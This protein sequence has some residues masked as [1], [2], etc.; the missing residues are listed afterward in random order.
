MNKYNKAMMLA[1]LAG[2]A[3]QA[4]AADGLRFGRVQVKDADVLSL[5]NKRWDKRI[6]LH[7][8]GKQSDLFRT[9]YKN[10]D[11]ETVTR[12]GRYLALFLVSYGIAEDM[13]QGKR[14]HEVPHCVFVERN[15]GCVLGEGSQFTCD[16]EWTQPAI[17]QPRDQA[18]WDMRELRSRLL[19]GDS[20]TGTTN[21]RRCGIH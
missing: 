15:T 9:V 2:L 12:R 6:Y 5:T 10:Y 20:T 4:S 18:A 7:E 1:L 17:W 3:H 14:Y 11:V 19:S 21:R 16:G 8:N 13:E